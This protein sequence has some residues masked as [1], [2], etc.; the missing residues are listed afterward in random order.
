MNGI[1]ALEAQGIWKK[2]ALRLALGMRYAMA[3][4]GRELVGVKLDGASLRA[5]EFWA[6]QDVSLSIARGQCIGLTGGNGSGKSTLLKLLA[7]ILR[8]DA[9]W[10]KR[11]GR[12]ASL[13][14]V[15]AGFHPMLTGR[16]NCFV[17]GAILGFSRRALRTVLDDVVGF[18]ELEPWIDMPIKHYSTG[19]TVRLGMAL[20]LQAAPDILLLDE[21]LAVADPVFRRKSLEA[22]REVQQHH[23]MACLIVTHHA[24]ELVGIADAMVHLQGGML[25][26]VPAMSI[27]GRKVAKP[28]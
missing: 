4:I 1:L 3:D 8:P 6:L 26:S 14:E 2:F 25:S 20:A 16:E 7:G 19:M 27:P 21:V 15:S 22:I 17:Q 23:G 10:V 11:C 9:G 13:V 24:D 12:L 28:G 18:A 5:G